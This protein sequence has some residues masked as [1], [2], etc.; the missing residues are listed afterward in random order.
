[1]HSAEDRK[2]FL[3]AH[4]LSVSI[5]DCSKIPKCL[6]FNQNNNFKQTQFWT[7][8]MASLRFYLDLRRGMLYKIENDFYCEYLKTQK[9]GKFVFYLK[10]HVWAD[11]D[12]KSGRVQ[13]LNLL[14]LT[15]M[16]SV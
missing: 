16:D 12:L 13:F 3:V 9:L 10:Q 11:I 7:V 14:T 15:E 6:F 1:M 4:L 2:W 5:F 8:C